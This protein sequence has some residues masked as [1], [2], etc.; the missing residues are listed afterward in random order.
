MSGVYEAR[1]EIEKK[2]RRGRPSQEEFITPPIVFARR[3]NLILI[4]SLPIFK[5][6]LICFGREKD[7]KRRMNA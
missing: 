1:V 7:Q 4:S 6:R 2:K 5:H 3:N